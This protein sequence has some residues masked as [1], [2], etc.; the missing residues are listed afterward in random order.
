MVIDDEE[1][2]EDDEDEEAVRAFNE[3]L[4]HMESDTAWLIKTTLYI[5]DGYTVSDRN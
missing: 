3:L 1:D 5:H 4:G 2:E